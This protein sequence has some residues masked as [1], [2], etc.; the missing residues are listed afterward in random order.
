M[1]YHPCSERFSPPGGATGLFWGEYQKTFVGVCANYS[2]K[3]LLADITATKQLNICKSFHLRIC[4]K[5]SKKY[6]KGK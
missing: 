2:M 6:F 4:R 3:Y 5:I 1:N